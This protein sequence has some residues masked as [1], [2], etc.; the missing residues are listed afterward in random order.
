M[1]LVEVLNFFFQLGSLELGEVIDRR[2]AFF[3]LF[4]QLYE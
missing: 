4:N 1:D 3:F 2:V